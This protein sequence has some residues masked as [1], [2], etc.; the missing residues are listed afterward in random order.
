M[1]NFSLKNCGPWKTSFGSPFEKH[2]HEQCLNILAYVPGPSISTPPQCCFISYTPVQMNHS[3]FPAFLTSLSLFSLFLLSECR[4]PG[5][6]YLWIP[7]TLPFPLRGSFL[8]EGWDS[9]VIFPTT[10]AVMTPR[11][12]LPSHAN[13]QFSLLELELK[14]SFCS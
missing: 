3:L 5:H 1:C 13:I 10:Q 12:P 2:S 8:L 9:F 14:V 4:L 11:Y 6:L 7:P